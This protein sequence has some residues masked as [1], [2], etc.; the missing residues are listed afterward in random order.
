MVE[1]RVSP[2]VRM[3]D[4]M[5]TH[6]PRDGRMTADEIRAALAALPASLITG[7]A[8]GMTLASVGE[9]RWARAGWRGGPLP[10]PL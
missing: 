2:A 1:D 9:S 7:D 4:E 6:V 8:G 3:E 10:P 5:H